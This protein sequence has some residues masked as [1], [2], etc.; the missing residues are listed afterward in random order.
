MSAKVTGAAVGAGVVVEV[1]RDDEA[2]AA[3]RHR[4][5]ERIRRVIGL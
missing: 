1:P 3:P 5:M 4:V 2:A